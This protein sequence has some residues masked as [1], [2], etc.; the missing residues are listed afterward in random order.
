LEQIANK[1]IGREA[2]LEIPAVESIKL[3]MEDLRQGLSL[4]YH[5]WLRFHQSTQNSADDLAVRAKL[6]SL[7]VDPMNAERMAFL[8]WTQINRVESF[9]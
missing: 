6:E 2:Q 5:R 9:L 8:V 4:A 1:N 7:A 3:L